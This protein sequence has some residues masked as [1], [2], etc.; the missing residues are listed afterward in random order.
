MGV[1]K[2]YV[3]L[4]GLPSKGN[5]RITEK[6]NPIDTKTYGEVT[7]NLIDNGRAL[8][9]SKELNGIATTQYA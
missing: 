1:Y 3:I 7:S 2:D 4:A 6:T 5:Y 8:E 9:K